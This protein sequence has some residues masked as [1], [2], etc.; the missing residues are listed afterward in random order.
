MIASLDEFRQFLTSEQIAQL[1][2]SSSNAPTADDVARLTEQITRSNADRKS[3]LFATRIQGLLRSIQQYCTIIDTCVSSNFAEYFD[4][5][6]QR[7]NQLSNY[8]PRLS[9][10]ERLFPASTRL[11]QAISSLYAVI[12]RFC[13][14]ALGVVQ[15]K[16]VKRY[17]KSAWKSFKIEFKDIEESISESKDEV[18]EELQL[19]SEQEA[20]SLRRLLTAEIDENRKMRVEQIAEIQANKDFR[21]QQTLELQRGG[22]RRIQKILKETGK[23]NTSKQRTGCGKTVLLG[24]IVDHLRTKFSA[25]NQ[26]LIVYYFF[27]SSEKKSLKASAFLRCILHQIIRP[28]TLLPTIQRRLESLFVDQIDESESAT[29]ELEELFLESCRTVQCCFLLLD[30]LDELNDIEQR[31]VKAFLRK[32]QKIDGGRVLTTTHAAMDMSKVFGSNLELH[33]RPEDLQND[34]DVFIQSQID[35]YSQEELSDC[36]P[37]VLDLIK[38]KLSNDAE[39]MFLWAHLQ[40][41]AVIDVYEEHGSPDRIPDILESLPRKITDLYAF[42]LERLAKD[43]KD[44]AERAKKI[45]Q[46]AIYSERPLTIRELEDALSVSADQKAWQSPPY[47]L[48][49]SRLAKMCGNLVNYD[50]A[51][52]TVL[53]AHH[54]VES[55]LLS[56]SSRE[57]VSC[58]AIEG[59]A[60]EQYLADICLTYLSFTDFHKAL[61][62]TSDSKYASRLN[63][64]IHLLESMTPGFIRPLAS[65]AFKGRQRRNASH[66][67][68][69]VNILRNELTTYQPKK[70]ESSYQMLEYCKRHWHSHSQ[71]ITLPDSIHFARVESFIRG[72]HLPKEWMPW[73]SIP[74]KELLPYWNMFL[75]ALRNGH[76]VIYCVWK[77]IAIIQE[78]KYWTLL[79]KQ[80]GKK[81]FSSACTSASLAQLEII[82]GAKLRD[83]LVTRPTKSEISHGLVKVSNLGHQEAV[84]RL[85]EAK[86]DVNAAAVA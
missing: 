40:L 59:T 42:L 77:K 44:R 86:A 64:P 58:F 41:K 12:V 13:S 85:L 29:S 49:M 76:I 48:D 39:G 18:I 61:T 20:H 14:K 83:N 38:Q 1:A 36:A 84:E 70:T 31:K 62:R 19:A 6:S 78:Y 52:G 17:S 60:T 25:Q 50:P 75:W 54:S 74:D 55:F 10:Y 26:T 80:E 33:I 2:S 65:N 63:R 43:T 22:D 79:W 45:F 9:E 53:L 8:C 82:L 35:E 11:Q 81:L 66:G 21:S 57:E 34:I 24:Y 69:V 5:L 4:K 37:I 3:R 30:G 71:Y 32:A 15:E 51:S 67:V 23:S 7:I 73:S 16:G 28:E 56:C 47:K 72:T 27:D 46:W 68:D